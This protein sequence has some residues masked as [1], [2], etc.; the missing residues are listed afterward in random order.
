M[1]SDAHP[2]GS[3][4]V[5]RVGGRRRWGRVRSIFRTGRLAVTGIFSR[6]PQK[7]LVA[8]RENGAL[9][10]VNE[11]SVA[12]NGQRITR[13]TVSDS[14]PVPSTTPSPT[15]PSRQQPRPGSTSYPNSQRKDYDDRQN[16]GTAVTIPMPASM[17]CPPPTIARPAIRPAQTNPF[18]HRGFLVSSDS[19]ESDDH[20]VEARIA[21]DTQA[22][23]NVMRVGI[24]QQLR[25]L[26]YQLESEA[27]TTPLRP[28]GATGNNG[29]VPLGIVR[30][31]N[32]YY[33]VSART[34]TADFHVVTVGHPDV[35]I[36]GPSI[37]RYNL[38]ERSP[39]IPRIIER[40]LSRP[41]PG[42]VSNNE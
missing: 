32:W 23:V 9:S 36:G 6:H 39:E 38:L 16:D 40:D 42:I 21:L 20:P 30:N 11:K 4:N 2:E 41:R 31:V 1:V 37:A 26:G 7:P 17:P 27:Q 13:P 19:T 14:Q 15:C 3:R 25:R 35:L 5:A 18:T 28:F 34:F 22:Q 8:R 10:S 12:E 33:R 24:F 29:V